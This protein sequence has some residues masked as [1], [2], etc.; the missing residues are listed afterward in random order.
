MPCAWSSTTTYRQLVGEIAVDAADDEVAD[1]IV[2]V[3]PGLT[4]DAVAKPDYP[5]HRPLKR[6]AAITSG[7]GGE[8]RRV[9]GCDEA[10][11]TGSGNCC[12]GPAAATAGVGGSQS[13]QS[14]KCLLV[15]VRAFTL[16]HRFLIGRHAER[17]QIGRYRLFR[18]GPGR[19]RRHPPI[20]ISHSPF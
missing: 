3:V 5:R 11:A 12:D 15:E 4:D 9:L 17:A 6:Q 19:S 14:V 20:R 10:L 2:Q 8:P 1:F 13:D 16:A 18:P 7:G